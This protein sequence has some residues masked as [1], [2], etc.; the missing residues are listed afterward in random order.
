M[1][2][3]IKRTEDQLALIRAMG[4]NNRE[5]AYEAQAAVAELLGPV[6]S[7]VI[8]NAPTIGN[9]YSTISYGEDD[10]PSLPLDLFHDIT[11]E[12]YIEVY[13][14]Q[15]AGGLPYSQVFPAHNELKFT[16]YTLDSAL[17]FDRKYVRKARLDVVSKTFTRMAQEVLL[18]QTTTAFNVLATALVKATG[19]SGAAGNSVI[20]SSAENRFVLAD[21]NNLITKSKRI[22]SSFSGGTPVGGVKSGI[23]DLLVSPEMVEEL[24]A[25]AYNPIN[26]AE[27]PYGSAVKDSIPAPDQLRQELFSAAGLPSFYGINVMEI[28]EMGV[29]QRF[30]KLFGAIVASEGATVAGHG[31]GGSDTWTT[32]SDEILIGIDRSKDALI[33]PTV[34]GEGSPAEFQVLVDDQFSVRQNK[35]GYYGKVEEGRLCIDNKALIGLVV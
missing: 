2:I 16:T 17:A 15:V 3:T 22:N 28:N 32:A 26:T 21:F 12:D 1:K 11:D 18:K 6:V 34:I 29:G 33:R 20:A 13:S 35:I 9:L 24:R 25:M 31:G 23:S 8:N 10:N 14:Q 5:E 30:N 4:S 27:A 19:T 7:E